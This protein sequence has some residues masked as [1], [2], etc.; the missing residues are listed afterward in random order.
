MGFQ[1]G[2]K[3]KLR[4][5]FGV[6]FRPRFTMAKSAWFVIVSRLNNPEKTA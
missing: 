1:D 6:M 2:S 5:G 4:V 3:F